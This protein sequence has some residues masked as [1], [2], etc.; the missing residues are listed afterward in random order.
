[1]E[2][3][4]GWMF[5]EG[6]RVCDNAEHFFTEEQWIKTVGMVINDQLVMSSLQPVCPFCRCGYVFDGQSRKYIHPITYPDRKDSFS[7]LFK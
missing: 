4:F 3:L 5:D 7:A 1:M 2:Q 6:M